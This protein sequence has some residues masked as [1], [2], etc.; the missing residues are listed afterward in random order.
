MAQSPVPDRTAHAPGECGR[1]SRSSGPQPRRCRARCAEP[2]HKRRV[3]SGGRA[4]RMQL[5][6][7]AGNRATALLPE[8]DPRWFPPPPPSDF[9]PLSALTRNFVQGYTVSHPGEGQRPDAGG[10]MFH[11]AVLLAL[12][13]LPTLIANGRHLP[14]RGAIAMINLFLGWTGIGW[15]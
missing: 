1:T 13:F 15:I 7:L 2:I 10:S 12:Y 3:D 8:A 14:E 4:L 5:Q 6:T 11:L 9:A